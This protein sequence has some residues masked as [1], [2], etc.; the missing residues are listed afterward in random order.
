MA[1]IIK[2]KVGRPRT[3]DIKIKRDKLGRPKNEETDKK[4]W[5]LTYLNSQNNLPLN[6]EEYNTIEQIAKKLNI[7]TIVAY[8]IQKGTKKSYKFYKIEKIL[9]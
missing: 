9:Y 7:S 2:R 3:K 4:K 1:D 6:I 5:R 8:S